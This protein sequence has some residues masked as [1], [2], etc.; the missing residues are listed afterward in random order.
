MDSQLE[1]LIPESVR[2]I[3]HVI[4]LEKALLLVA[5]VPRC[6]SGQEG[7]KSWHA[8]LY[9]P[10]SAHLTAQHFLVRVL[11]WDDAKAMCVEFGGLIMKLPN[12]ADLA[13]HHRNR[14]ILHMVYE[15]RISPRDAAEMTGVGLRTVQNLMKENPQEV[16]QQE[17]EQYSSVPTME[18]TKKCSTQPSSMRFVAGAAND[19]GPDS[20]M[21]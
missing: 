10:T 1:E 3:A 18:P 8:I 4:G 13:R 21:V 7:K 16:W 6:F 12:C 20:E 15:N 2:E 9:I 19:D 17:R 14:S 11:G 5:K